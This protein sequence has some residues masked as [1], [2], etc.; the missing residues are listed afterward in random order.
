MNTTEITIQKITASENMWLAP[1][2]NS[3]T[4]PVFAKEVY[5][6]VND[7]VSNWHEVT[8]AEKVAAEQSAAGINKAYIEHLQ[9]DA[10]NIGQ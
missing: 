9:A 8:D 10:G 1:V 4:A 6:G 7:D 3:N 5:L 2:N